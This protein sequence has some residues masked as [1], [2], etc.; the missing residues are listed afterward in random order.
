M[1]FVNAAND[2][3]EKDLLELEVRL[4][5]PDIRHSRESLSLLLAE[6]FREFGSSGRVYT[7]SEI[8]DALASETTAPFSISDFLAVPLSAGAALV[9]YRASRPGSSSLR[10]SVWVRRDDRWQILFHQG[11]KTSLVP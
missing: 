3:L 6:E 8:I 2:P 10:S 7:R 1:L 11:T 5:Q 9:T 4:L